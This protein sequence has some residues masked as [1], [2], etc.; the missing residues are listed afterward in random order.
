MKVICKDDSSTH[1]T[2][3]EE[4]VV[5]SVC[6]KGDKG[7]EWNFS[8]EAF[9]KHFEVAKEEGVKPKG[10]DDDVKVKLHWNSGDITKS[11]VGASAW[12]FSESANVTH[13][14]V[15]QPK[16][17]KNIGVK[18][19]KGEW[20]VEVKLKDGDIVDGMVGQFRWSLERRGGDIVEWKL[21]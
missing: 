6:I 17:K 21:I 11:T 4:Y 13:Y 18:K 12:Y 19:G 9:N 2:K 10:L 3:G 1:F 20:D 7:I 16:R 8:Y 15:K 14:K 5:E